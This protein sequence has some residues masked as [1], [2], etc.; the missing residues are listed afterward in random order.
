MV[1][2]RKLRYYGDWAFVDGLWMQFI[3]YLSPTEELWTYEAG[4]K[5][6]NYHRHI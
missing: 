3:K 5:E 6:C 4:W 2:E 1:I